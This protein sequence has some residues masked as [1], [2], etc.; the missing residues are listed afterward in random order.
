MLLAYR[1][2]KLL[3]VRKRFAVY[4][5]SQKNLAAHLSAS[6]INMAQKATAT[7]LVIARKIVFFEEGGTRVKNF[8]K[9]RRR[10]W[11]FSRLG[12]TVTFRSV[13]AY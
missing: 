12:H 6:Q 3:C 13:E 4:N 5:D 1:C 9:N 8:S 10:E 2:H 11:T 7:L